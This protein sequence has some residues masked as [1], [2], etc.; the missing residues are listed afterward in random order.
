M[1]KVSEFLK[2]EREKKGYSL[3]D[4]EQMT[5][6]RKNFLTAIEEGRFYKLP[7]EA[8]ALGF[9]KNYA[10]FLGLPKNKIIALFRREYELFSG[11]KNSSS[12]DTNW[13]VKR[14]NRVEKEEVIPRYRKNTNRFRK[15]RLFSA[16]ALLIVFLFLVVLSYIFFQ[17]NSIIFGPP[18]SLTS[19]KNNEVFR[20]SVVEIAGETDPYSTVNIDGE[21]AY[22]NL[23]GSFKKSLYV[24]PGNKKITVVAKNR[25]GKETKTTVNIT[26]Q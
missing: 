6:I 10:E 3:E 17:Y 21:D 4:I 11:G 20:E 23:D 16:K 9:V 22:V 18:L 1:R 19:P 8:Y 26:V 12:F 7:S 15:S 5:K 25:Y 2:E 14:K 24:F 13:E